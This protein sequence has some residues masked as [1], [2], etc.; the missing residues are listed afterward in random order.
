MSDTFRLLNDPATGTKVGIGV[1]TGA[2]DIYCIKD[3]GLI[4]PDR[5]LPMASGRDLTSG[6]F[7]WDGDYL[8]NVWLPDGS[9]VDLADYPRLAAHLET[10]RERLRGRHTAK[11]NPARWHRTIDKVNHLLLDKPLLMMRDLGMAANPV[12]VPAGY[13]PHHNI[14]WV[15]STMWDLEVLGGLLLARTAQAFIEAFCVRMRGGTLRFQAQYLRQIRVPDP[16]S[17]TEEHMTELRRAFL[18]RDANRATRAA[19][20]VLDI[21]PDEFEL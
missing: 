2:D 14:Y 5:T 17:L 18:D 8:V 16:N 7:V 6:T 9:L 10:A 4:E 1:A 19:C 3:P 15:S 21:D 12:L 20:S 13:Y 11:M